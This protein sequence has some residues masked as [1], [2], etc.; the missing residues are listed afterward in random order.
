MRGN[1]LENLVGNLSPGTQHSKGATLQ[2]L[3]LDD[4]LRSH[5]LFRGSHSG[6]AVLSKKEVNIRRSGWTGRS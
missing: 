6:K 4:A 3:L 5:G 2:E 1:L